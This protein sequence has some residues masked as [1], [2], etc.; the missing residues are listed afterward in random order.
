MNGT[1]AGTD[2]EFG[3]LGPLEL[4]V[5]GHEVR[6]T[7]K[8]RSLLALLL[9]A[10]NRVVSTDQ[11][12]QG[13]W[14]ES[15]PAS[16]AARIRALVTDLRRA[17][18]S[19]GDELIVTRKPG[20]VLW[21]QAARL[22]VDA[23][24]L[25]VEQARHDIKQDLPSDAVERYDEALALWR[26]TPL[27]DVEAGAI[28][29]DIA[30]LEEQRMDALE[31]RANAKLLVGR[32]IEVVSELTS[33]SAAH[34]MHERLR[35]L[36]MLA[37]YRSGRPA[38]AL[39]VFADTRKVLADE[40]GID[41]S[42]E[43]ADL[44]RRILDADPE[45]LHR[46]SQPEPS[47]ELVIPAQLPASVP[48]FTG[49]DSLVQELDRQLTG[50]Q[51]VIMAISAVTGIGGVGKTA[52]AVRVA[53]LLRGCYPNGQLYV[54]LQG[55]GGN[56]ADPEV[57]LGAFLR[58]LGVSNSKIPAALEERAALY[59]STLSGRRVLILLDDA[60]DAAHV[61]PLLPGAP[62]C[63]V[64]ITSRILM[65]D[66]EG[67]RQVYL[68]VMTPDEALELFSKILGKDRVEAEH[69]AALDVVAACGYLPL[70]V[71]IAASRLVTR[72]AWTL[73]YMA[74]RL[75]DERQTLDELQTG[76][77][78]VRATF[79]LSYA[80]LAPEH[81]R[82]F[83]LL[84]FPDS[85]VFS[86]DMAAAVLDMTEGGAGRIL[87][88]L[89]D[90]NLIEAVSPERY[91]YHDLLRIYARDRV[92]RFESEESKTAALARLMDFYLASTRNVYELELPGDRALDH[93][94]PVSRPG[95]AF[96]SRGHAL[97]WLFAEAPGLL[98]VAHQA[99]A[100]GSAATLRQAAE[101]L[102]LTNTLHESGSHVRQFEQVASAV[103]SA[104]EERGDEYS[105]GRARVHRA[106]SLMSAGRIAESG[107][108]ARRA[109]PLGRITGDPVTFGYAHNLLGI[110]ERWAGR[111][112]ES[113]QHYTVALQSFREDGNMPAEASTLGNLSRLQV[114]LGD[115]DSA[116]E[117]GRRM[118][119][120]YKDLGAGSRY[121]NGLYVMGVAL[122]AAARLGNAQMHLTEAMGIFQSERQRM[123]EGLTHF[124][125]ADMHIR[126][127]QWQE[128]LP[129]AE[130]SVAILKEV[131]AV[132]Q[133]AEALKLLARILGNFG[134]DVRAR[135]CRREAL[136]VN[137]G[138]EAQETDES[139][140]DR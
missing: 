91:R 129:H 41:P 76:D 98:V 43:L 34:P 89:A 81:A 109:L 20:Y 44:H 46:P 49:R 62:G 125:L 51:S 115:V 132:Q 12:A 122:T 136:A 77:L 106:Q 16:A 134:Q 19:T 40:L 87:E 78:A 56:P 18:G 67:A 10:A 26:G 45:L 6:L 88:S 86:V 103:M 137:T 79:E 111:F 11:L 17:L 114:E 39:G 31:E 2:V 120:I 139:Q 15:P 110:S 127:D 126:A 119:D 60:R 8:Q 37:L 131:G 84:A 59:R 124:R 50:D 123:W 22:D 32:H 93:L 29:A 64:V 74:R 58:A 23:F 30:R 54:D 82:A 128:A 1:V 135:A 83:R 97:E 68:G 90:M 48:D 116:V 85:I 36:L 70:A 63:G 25:L 33:L 53:H 5:A 69:Q 65:G 133:A 9:L 21:T 92:E 47:A 57:V 38:E 75:S 100:C 105:E 108:E 118:A 35:G 117:N 24:G 14:G 42:A 99:A 61:R 104:A 107:M 102:L 113:V 80:H 71:R 52:L 4:S 138:H 55:N 13:I 72:R 140:E 73:S 94:S 101:L 7:G 66:L 27:A 28:E 95:L 3:L 96:T 112:A 130:H 121:G